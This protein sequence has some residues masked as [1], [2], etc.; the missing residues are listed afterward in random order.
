MRPCIKFTLAQRFQENYKIFLGMVLG[1]TH[2]FG[3]GSSNGNEHFQEHHKNF[4]TKI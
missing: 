1:Q 4:K 2:W 3:I